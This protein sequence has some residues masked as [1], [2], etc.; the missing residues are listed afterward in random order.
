[1]GRAPEDQGEGEAGH[2]CNGKPSGRRRRDVA[3]GG[4]ECQRGVDSGPLRN[5]LSRRPPETHVGG[6]PS[7]AAG[8]P[9]RRGGR[10]VGLT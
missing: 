10:R 1:M 5:T 8:L 6:D 4:G 2:S 7:P 9:W 3:G